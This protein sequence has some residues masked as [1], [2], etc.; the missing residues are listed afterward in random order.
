MQLNL[1]SYNF[2]QKQENEKMF[3]FDCIRKKYVVCTSEEWVRQNF[4]QYMINEKHYP[5][6]LLAVEYSFKYFSMQRRADIV[7]FDLKGIPKLIVECKA[8]E[9][10]I[11]QNVFNQIAMYNISLKVP[12]LVVT[13]GLSHFCCKINFENNSYDFLTE[14]PSFELIR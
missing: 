11:S 10:K 1:P 2:K 13:N 12:Y 4:I 5:I 6:A 8:P 9:V 3:I 14:I 7:A